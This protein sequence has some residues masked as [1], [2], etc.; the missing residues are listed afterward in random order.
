MK[1]GVRVTAHMV[2]DRQWGFILVMA[3]DNIKVT[4]M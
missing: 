2:H 1:G 4:G 3:A